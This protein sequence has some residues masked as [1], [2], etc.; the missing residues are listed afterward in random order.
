[1]TSKILSLLKDGINQAERFIPSLSPDYVK[2]D[3]RDIPDL[4]T[5][6]SE[7]SY[8]LN[9]YN[10]KNQID[11]DWGDLLAADPNIL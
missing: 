9:Y 7:L 11:G 2:M 4:L 3:G 6:I 10:F 8:Q 1:M 5:F